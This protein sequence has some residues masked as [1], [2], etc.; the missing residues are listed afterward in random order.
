MERRFKRRSQGDEL[1][2]FI[3]VQLPGVSIW[4]FEGK[5]QKGNP[6]K[7]IIGLKFKGVTRS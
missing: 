6:T 2:F 5:S 7:N 4:A 3:F 1:L